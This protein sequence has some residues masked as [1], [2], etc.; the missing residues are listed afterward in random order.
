MVQG[1]AQA[2]SLQA[3]QARSGS[4]K[5]RRQAGSVVPA[6]R[7]ERQAR[8]EAGRQQQGQVRWCE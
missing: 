2:E 8:R 4:E 7:A 6:V 3:V 5:K 1:M